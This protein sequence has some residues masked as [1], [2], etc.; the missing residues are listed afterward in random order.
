MAFPKPLFLQ[1]LE[2]AIKTLTQLTDEKA[3]VKMCQAA[4]EEAGPAFKVPAG[5]T[6]LLARLAAMAMVETRVLR[7][8]ILTLGVSPRMAVV[9]HLRLPMDGSCFSMLYERLGEV[10][11]WSPSDTAHV[12]MVAEQVSSKDA[13]EYLRPT[14][15][16]ELEMAPIPPWVQREKVPVGTFNLPHPGTE[17]KAPTCLSADLSRLKGY[18]GDNLQLVDKQGSGVKVEEIYPLLQALVG[19][20]HTRQDRA[21][22]LHPDRVFG[23]LNAKIGT[24]CRSGLLGGCRMLTCTCLEKTWFTEA[25]DVCGQGIADLSHAIRRPYS[26]GG[27]LGC[28]CSEE[29]V[30]GDKSYTHSGMDNLLLGSTVA[31]LKV[32]GIIDR[33]TA[34]P[35]PLPKV[36]ASIPEEVPDR[37]AGITDGPVELTQGPLTAEVLKSLGL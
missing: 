33:T 22:G 25:C 35:T 23:P 36:D 28:Y 21:T 5:S 10:V 12:A 4:L 17:T 15:K 9:D 1:R 26:S 3:D 29:C 13:L 11:E 8:L 6:A 16:V 19:G 31:R 7:Y 30:A 34:E 18:F 20:G 32:A 37:S 14:V 24:E 2:T 27:W